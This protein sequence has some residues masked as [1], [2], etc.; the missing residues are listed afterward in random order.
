MFYKNWLRQ[1]LNESDKR[2]RIVNKKVIKPKYKEIGDKLKISTKKDLKI[3]KKK[4]RNLKDR[5]KLVTTHN[6]YTYR[7][8]CQ[9]KTIIG[10]LE[11]VRSGVG[12]LLTPEDQKD[13]K[14]P[15]KNLVNA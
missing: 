1:V 13:I 3:L 6:N 2:F 10:Y 9:I 7:N 11:I 8:E 5:G 14:I 4:L 12:F 15:R